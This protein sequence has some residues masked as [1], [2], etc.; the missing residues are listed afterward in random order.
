MSET[1]ERQE[2][3]SFRWRFLER[4]EEDDEKAKHETCLMV[5]ASGEVHSESSYFSDDNSPIDDTILDSEDNKLCKMSLKI[6]TKNKNLKA[7]RNS[8]ENEISELKEKL[9]K[10]ERNK[11]VDLECTTCQTLKTDNEKLKEEAFKLT[12]FQKSTH[13]LNEMLSL[14][15][16]SGDKSGLGFNSIEASTNGIKKT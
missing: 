7:I 9:S 4:Y 1:T 10:L 11:G 12:Q 14:K 2:P 6:I 8:L 16:P 15:K 3:K 5:H 13:S